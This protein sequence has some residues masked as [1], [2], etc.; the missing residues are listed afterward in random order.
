MPGQMACIHSYFIP[1]AQITQEHNMASQLGCPHILSAPPAGPNGLFH[2]F[3]ALPMPYKVQMYS[4]W[5]LSLYVSLLH[6]L[7]ETNSARQQ[8]KLG[9]LTLLCLFEDGIF[10]DSCCS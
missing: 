10:R 4:I 3:D 8:Q 6:L 9:K 2:T 7:K 1:P 5:Y